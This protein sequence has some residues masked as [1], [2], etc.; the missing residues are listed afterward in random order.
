MPAMLHLGDAEINAL[1]AYLEA[2][3]GVP[4][5]SGRQLRINVPA[6]RI[7]EHLVKGTCHICHDAVGR[8]PGPE[9]LMEGVVPSLESLVRQRGVASVI[10]KVRQGGTVMNSLGL[11]YR[12]RMP[13]F[14]YLTEAE[15][16]AAYQYLVRYPPQPGAR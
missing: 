9:A 8:W 14:S 5:A 10:G 2:L 3:A 12:G 6:M 11:T 15:I 13:E 4:G 7:G 1:L 16:A